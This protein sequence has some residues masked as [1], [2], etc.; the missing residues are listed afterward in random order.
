MR[1]K[2]YS[3]ANMKEYFTFTASKNL[4]SHEFH[5]WSRASSA[6]LKFNFGAGPRV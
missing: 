6:V 1:T 3:R 2:A 5:S 4:E